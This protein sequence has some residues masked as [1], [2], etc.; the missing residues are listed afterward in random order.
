MHCFLLVGFFPFKWAVSLNVQHLTVAAKQVNGLFLQ[1]VKSSRKWS[2][3]KSLFAVK[4]S[5]SICL[6]PTSASRDTGSEQLKASCLQETLSSGHPAASTWAGAGLH[7]WD[8][9]SHCI[10]NTFLPHYWGVNPFLPTLRSRRTLVAVIQGK[11]I[12]RDNIWVTL[13]ESAPLK[14]SGFPQLLPSCLES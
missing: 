13:L 1:P 14:P 5:K 8:L 10:C 2:G 3:F 7:N 4:L 12:Y 6:S 11:I 9:C